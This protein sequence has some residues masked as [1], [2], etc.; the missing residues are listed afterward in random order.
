VKTTTTERGHLFHIIDETVKELRKKLTEDYNNCHFSTNDREFWVCWVH[1]R[2][3]DITNESLKVRLSNSDPNGMYIDS[4]WDKGMKVGFSFIAIQKDHSDTY[5]YIPLI[6]VTTRINNEQQ[7]VKTKLRLWEHF[8]PSVRRLKKF[9]KEARAT[10][11]KMESI[12]VEH[13]LAKI[14]PNRIDD[15]LLEGEASHEKN[16]DS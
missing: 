7:T 8:H 1:P 14:I 13:H 9:L 16:R 4:D 12:K 5:K 15:I 6:F 3:L 2:P 10:K 11:V